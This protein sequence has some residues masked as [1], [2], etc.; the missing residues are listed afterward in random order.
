MPAPADA[1]YSLQAYIAAHTSFRDLIDSGTGDG[2]VLVLNAADSVLATLPLNKPCGTV[3]ETTGVLAFNLAAAGSAAAALDG[4]AA[5]AAFCDSAGNPHLLLP[6][7][8]GTAAVPGRFVMNT[9]AVLAASTVSL[10]AAT[11]G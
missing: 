4:T 8:E 2:Y 1:T 10:V 3:S 11:V 5:Y 6:A 7:V 9:L